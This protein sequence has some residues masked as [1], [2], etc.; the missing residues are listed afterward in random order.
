[1]S[2]A[3]RIALAQAAQKRGITLPTA[4]P[5][6][7]PEKHYVELDGKRYHVSVLNIV[8]NVKEYYGDKISGFTDGQIVEAYSEWQLSED[9]ENKDSFPG[10]LN[11]KFGEDND[12]DGLGSD[13]EDNDDDSESDSDDSDDSDDDSDDSDGSDSDDGGDS[14][15]ASGN[16][17]GELV[18]DAEDSESDD[19]EFVIGEDAEKMS[20]DS[21]NSKLVVDEANSESDML[22]ADRI[23]AAQE[24]LTNKQWFS[25]LV[26]SLREQGEEAVKAEFTSI[27][28]RLFKLNTQTESGIL[29]SIGEATRV[30][31]MLFGLFTALGVEIPRTHVAPT[32]VKVG[33]REIVVSQR[34][35]RYLM[36][37]LEAAT[38]SAASKINS[39]MRVEAEAQASKAKLA[40]A[41]AEIEKLKNNAA[42]L[43]E[44]DKAMTA[45]ALAAE[46]RPIAAPLL[47]EGTM[48]VYVIC[49]MVKSSKDEN[50]Y[51][52]MYLTVAADVAEPNE[53]GHYPIA[54]YRRTNGFNTA[55]MF[56]SVEKAQE[57]LARL[58]KNFAKVP[59]EA[60]LKEASLRKAQILQI[61]VMPAN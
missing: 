40:N 12:N 6:P 24:V 2:E 15:G 58:L 41:M 57:T 14:A 28:E 53:K 20:D 47:Y 52:P 38:I 44:Q 33:D 43:I 35:G 39:I 56:A 34:N 54:S 30:R 9:F 1:M 27:M 10:Y 59:K 60:K 11:D 36:R 46:A 50:L 17:D 55:L 42:A 26:D 29:A 8:R 23:A 32:M 16:G 7:E 19:A 61:M 31:D 13:S 48:P 5:T 3:M 22:P 4:E 18:D 25:L 51:V 45:R 21:T 37:E 49:W